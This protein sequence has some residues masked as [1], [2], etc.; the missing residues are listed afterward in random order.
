MDKEWENKDRGTM[1]KMG[2]GGKGVKSERGNIKLVK[3]REDKKE[4]KGK[5]E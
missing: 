2:R 1:V 5:R 3:R 4:K